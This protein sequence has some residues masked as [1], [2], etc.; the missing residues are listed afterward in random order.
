MQRFPNIPGYEI[1]QRLGGGLLTS[2]YAARD[3]AT[4]KP[5]AVKVLREDWEDPVTGIK[6]LQREAR[7]GL[8]VRDPRLVRIRHVHVLTAPYFLVM[9]LLAGESLRLRLRREYR[10][11]LADALWVSRQ[12]AQA[13]AA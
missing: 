5:C 8:I 9:D 6:L 10:L 2:V 11:D 7:V 12:T 13:L 1:Y 4:D 3:C